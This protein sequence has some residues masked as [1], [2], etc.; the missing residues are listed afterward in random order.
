MARR[1]RGFTLVELL[2]VIGI[3]AVLISILVPALNRARREAKRV[4]CLSNMRQ[5][6]VGF[7]LYAHQYDDSLVPSIYWKGAAIN[8]KNDDSWAIVLVAT[9]CV[10]NPHISANSSPYASGIFVCPE[11]AEMMSTTNIPGLATFGI[12]VDGFDR[13]QS[14]WMRPG[15]I[16]DS[17]YC[18][19]GSVDAPAPA[20]IEIY[21]PTSGILTG[22]PVK[23]NL[24][25]LSAIP[26]PAD[27]II[28]LDGQEWN[29]QNPSKLS[30]LTGAFRISGARHGVFDPNN[31]FNTGMTNV[32]CL[33]GHAESVNRADLPAQPS[34]WLVPQ[35]SPGFPLKMSVLQ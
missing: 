9:Q 17:A 30:S 34:D 18:I 23:S 5:L 14:N 20:P 16:V 21:M 28:L 3:I 27:M 32:L 10:P 1:R 29:P 8:Q 19:N 26:H 33:D 31:P 24:R 15:L 6:G 11:V 12:N 13:R 25:R 4:Q 22:P 35:R 7:A 2:V